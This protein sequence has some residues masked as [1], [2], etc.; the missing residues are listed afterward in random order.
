MNWREAAQKGT[1]GRM[2]MNDPTLHPETH[3]RR[4]GCLAMFA[5]A[6]FS[7]IIITLLV[8]WALA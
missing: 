7:I 5:S 3:P 8:K 2:A 1:L 4:F 6:C